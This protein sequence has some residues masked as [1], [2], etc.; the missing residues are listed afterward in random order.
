MRTKENPFLLRLLICC[1]IVFITDKGFSVGLGVYGFDD[2]HTLWVQSKVTQEVHRTLEFLTE[3]E[4]S[5]KSFTQSL[6]LLVN[7]LIESYQTRDAGDIYYLNTILTEMSALSIRKELIEVILRFEFD[8]LKKEIQVLFKADSLKL[9]QILYFNNGEDNII[10][11]LYKIEVLAKLYEFNSLYTEV[12]TFRES[13]TNEIQRPRGILNILKRLR[14]KNR[15][16][17]LF[18]N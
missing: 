6:D 16:S 2:K 5:E 13:T 3:G 11:L 1:F 12:Y 8:Y 18:V 14:L 10:E 4:R 15:C 7:H 17:D 9:L